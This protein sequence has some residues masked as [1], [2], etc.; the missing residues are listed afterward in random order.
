MDSG[1]GG[2]KLSLLLLL[3]A[4]AFSQSQDLSSSGSCLLANTFKT[5]KKYEYEYTAETENG[6]MG[7]AALTNGPKLSCKVVIEVPQ[8]CRFILS[9]SQCQLSETFANDPDG[10]PVTQPAAGSGAFQA[11]MEKNSLKF[12][13]QDDGEV[14]LFPETDETPTILNVK[15]GIVSALLVPVMEEESSKYME[16]LYGLCKT[17]VTV[18][19][20]GNIANNVTFIR[21][22]SK[23]DRF[24]PM[25]DF[26]SPLAL[27]SGLDFPLSQLIRS[28]Q[29][30]NYQFDD[31]MQHMTTGTCWEKHMF[32][33]FSNQQIYGISAR[34]T[35]TLRLVDSSNSNSRTYDHNEA[36]MKDLYME[37]TADKAPTQIKDTMLAS[38][39]ELNA[40][41]Q[42]DNGEKRA[43]LFHKLVSEI[44]QLRYET[45]SHAVTEMLEVSSLLTW[46]ALAQCGTPECTSAI[47]RIL[48]TF[49]RSSLEIDAVVY[50]MGFL[51]NVNIQDML[52]MAQYKQSKAIMYSLSNTVRRFYQSEL[53]VTPEITA[54]SEFMGSQ[55]GS[56]CSGDKDHIFLTLRV[57]GNM[58]EAMEAASPGLK[59]VLLNCISQPSA[60]LSVQQAAI[61]AFRQMRADE[62]V[63][64]IFLRVVLDGA[65]PVQK[66]LAA[67]LIL[68][69]HPEPA[70]V[71][72][73]IKALP[74]EQ[75][76]QA[77][78]F[79][80]SYLSNILIS[81]DPASED[82]KQ[83]ILDALQG[84]DLP[85]AQDFRKFSQNY[86][87]GIMQGNT[88]FDST[89]YMPK[90]VML[91]T[92]LKA[93]GYHLDLFEVGMEG[94]G[95]EPTIDALFGQNGFFPDIILKTMY[96]A[97]NKMPEKV[98]E[99]LKRW[100]PL[101]KEKTKGQ[102][103]QNIVD[104]IERNFDKLLHELRT[105]QSPEAMAYLRIMGTEL[106]YIKTSEIKGIT[107]SVN[108][109]VDKILRMF[110]KNIL[111]SFLSSTDNEMFAHYIFMD[112]R[113]SL[114]TVAGF[115]LKFSLSAT[116]APGAKGGLRMA[117]RLHEL[118]F[119]PSVGVEFIT[120]MGVHIPEYILSSIDMHT[121]VYHE[122]KL[123][124]RLSVTNNQIKLAFPVPQDTTKLFSISNK[125]LSV[126]STGTLT[127][128]PSAAG[129][130]E[131][132]ECQPLFSGVNYCTTLQYTN[133]GSSSDVPY[134]PLTGESKFAVEVHPTGE[135]TEYTA[136]IT[137]ET[138]KEGK[139]GQH[140]VDT[141]KMTLKA[142]GTQPSEATATV[143]YNRSK[144]VLST[145]IQIPDYDVE[146]GI[147]LSFTDSNARKKGVHSITI[148][149]VNKNV[150]QLS[151]IGRTK[152]EGMKDGQVQLQFIFPALKTEA[153]LTATM[154]NAEEIILDIN[155]SIRVSETSSLQHVI[156]KYDGNI[157]EVELVSDMDSKIQDYFPDTEVYQK[158]INHIL[159]QKVAKTDMKLRHIV[160]KSYEGGQ[161][162]LRK[163]AA[164]VPLLN[165]MEFT[166]PSLP[167]KLFLKSKS[168]F[169]WKFQ[170]RVIV[171][172]A[173]PFG[174][175]SSKR[176]NI[177]EKITVPRLSIPQIGL[178]VPSTEVR[179]PV[180]H[181]P[182]GFELSLPLNDMVEF[183]TVVNSN[184][185]NWEG[186]F[187]VGK[188]TETSYVT[189]FKAMA[190]CPLELLSYSIGGGAAL[191][192]SSTLAK[193][194]TDFSLTH[195]LIDINFNTSSSLVIF[196]IVY[197]QQTSTLKA[198]SPLGLETS[199]YHTYEAKM[200]YSNITERSSTSGSVMVGS[201][202]GNI[203]HVYSG[204][205]DT[206]LE[207]GRAESSLTMSSDVLQAENR[208]VFL[209][210]TGKLAVTSTTRTLNDAVEHMLEFTLS[211]THL[212][213][214]S[215]AVA[216]V[217][218]ITVRNQAELDLSHEAVSITVKSRAYGPRLH[219]FSL[220]SGSLSEN[221]L[222]VQTDNSVN[223]DKSLHTNNA[224]LII[225]LGRL[226]FH[227]N[228]N[229]QNNL[230]TFENI[231][232]GGID[233]TGTSLS[234]S[235][236]GLVQDMKTESTNTLSL[237]STTLLL[238]S[239]TE[240]FV[241][242]SSFYKHNVDVDLK[243]FTGVV[244]MS[245]DL[246]LLD[247]NFLHNGQFKL[248]P[249]K[250]DL[251]GNLKGIIGEENIMHRY[252][253]SFSDLNLSAKSRTNGNVL[254]AH[255]NYISDMEATRLS[256]R[257]NSEVSIKSESLHVTG[258][259]RTLVQ[260][261][262]VSAD[263]ILNSNGNLDWYG[264][265]TSQLYSKLAFKAEPLALACS[266]DLRAST[267]HQLDDT[268]S[269][270]TQLDH[271]IDTLLNPQEQRGMWKVKS[272]LNNHAYDKEIS[273]YNS[274]ERMGIEMSGK[275]T[276]PFLNV[277]DTENQELS[278]SAYLKYDKMGDSHVVELP[279]IISLSGI[280]ERLKMNIVSVLEFFKQNIK[281]EEFR[282]KIQNM[283]KS[284]S[285]YV[286][287]YD[288][289]S[290][291][292]IIK[293]KLI[294]LSREYTVTSENFETF[295]ENLKT[296][297]ER[298]QSYVQVW[299]QS[300]AALLTDIFE[301]GTLGDSV[302]NLLQKLGHEMRAIDAQ[303]K[304][305]SIVVRII[306][307]FEEI[308]I[309][310]QYL[311]SNFAGLQ[312][313][314]AKYE[315][316]ANLLKK[317]GELEQY[318]DMFDIMQLIQESNIGEYVEHLVS[319][320]PIEIMKDVN[321]LKQVIISF[322]EEYDIIE[323]INTANTVLHEMLIKY[324]VDTKIEL[325][326]D[327]VMEFIKLE[328]NKAI[329]TLKH[330]DL[331]TLCDQAIHDLDNAIN[332][333]M[334]TDFREM[335]GQL[336]N[337]IDY[338]A[339][340]M[341]SVDMIRGEVKFPTFGKLYSEIRFNSP[342]Y[343]LIT[344]AELLNSTTSSTTP[345][346]T[347]LL[348][349]KAS[350]AF[351]VLDY[352][353]NATALLAMPTMNHLI[354]DENCMINHIVFSVDHQ[355]SFTV[356]GIS[357]QA[358]GK[359]ITR[360]S[361][362]PY[363]AEFVNNVAL[364]L[365]SEISMTVDNTYSH[366]LNMPDVAVSSRASGTQR[367]YANL[368]SG[369][370]NV[371][372]NNKANGKW[373][374]Q[375]Y[376]DEGSH[377]SDI[378]FT[379][380]ITTAKFNI[381]A[382]TNIQ[383]LKAKQQL[384][385]D[386][387]MLETININGLAETESP[388]IK[389]SMVE[390][391]GNVN[392][393]ELSVKLNVSHS[394]ELLGTVTG[395]I[396][397]SIFFYAHPEELAFDF[398]NK[399]N[400]KISLPVGLTAK[401]DLQNDYSVILKN[402]LQQ[403][404]WVSLARFNQYK[405]SHNFTMNNNNKDAGIYAKI[406]GDAN[407]DFLDVSI[408][409]PAVDMLWYRTPSF[410]KVSLWKHTG[411][412]NILTTPQQSLNMDYRLLY[413]KTQDSVNAFGNLTSDLSFKS[414]IITLNVNTAL[415]KQN[416]IVAR[417]VVSSTSVFDALKG[418]FLGNINLTTKKMVKLAIILSAE[419]KNFEATHSSAVSRTKKGVDVSM[420]TISKV[421]CPMIHLEFNQELTGNS[422]TTSKAISR[423]KLKYSFDLPI[424][425]AIGQ[426][427][428]GHHFNLEGTL[429]D[430]SLETITKGKTV[431][432]INSNIKFINVINHD[433]NTFMNADGLRSSMKT[434]VIFQ[435][436]HKDRKTWNM[437][438]KQDVA[439]DA[440]LN[441]VYAVLTYTNDNEANLLFLNTKGK[442]IATATLNLSPVTSLTGKVHID[443]SQPT[444]FGE[445]HLFQDIV[446]EVT[447]WKQNFSWEGSEKLSSL[448]HAHKL[449]LSNNMAEQK[450]EVSSSW[451]GHVAFLKSIN[452]PIYQKNLW[453]VLKFDQVT[454]AEKLQ[455]LK[456]SSDVVH[457]QSQ[458]GFG[459]NEISATATLSCPVYTMTWT[460][461][462][463]NQ[464]PKFI[465]SLKSS[466]T[467]TLVFLEFDLD[468]TAT[469][470]FEDNTVGLSGRGTFRHHD[471]NIDWKHVCTHPLSTS[472]HTLTVDVTSPTFTNLKIQY[473]SQD[474]S[475]NADIFSS[476]CGLL[477]FRLEKKTPSQIYGLL[478]S[479]YLNAPETDTDILSIRVS[480]KNPERLSLQTSWNMRPVD[481]MT[482][483]LVD[484]VP[485]ITASFA[486]LVNKYHK[487]LFG[488][489]IKSTAQELKRTV[490]GSIEEAYRRVT[491]EMPQSSNM[492]SLSVI[493]RNVVRQCNKNM[494]AVF[495]SA[496]LALSETYI[497]LPG[498]H[499][500]LTVPQ[501]WEGTVE[502]SFHVLKIYAHYLGAVTS[503]FSDIMVVMPFTENILTWKE[504]LEHTEASMKNLDLTTFRDLF[505]FIHQLVEHIFGNLIYEYL[506]PFWAS[507]NKIYS[508]ALFSVKTKMG[509]FQA[510]INME[511]LNKVLQDMIGAIALH[512]RAFG[513]EVIHA[514]QQLASED[515]QT[516]IQISNNH[517]EI[518]IPL[519]LIH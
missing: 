337:Y 494:Q 238:Q 97:E 419:S 368:E 270:K 480:L 388:F 75:D 426:G 228:T 490:Y 188:D 273:V 10:V 32:L 83:M 462:L 222:E 453:E 266:H 243:P 141:L 77:K 69:K 464:A 150:P 354:I 470:N 412:M 392:M 449:L 232:K 57:L 309:R 253:V 366:K 445:G 54:V 482:S 242:K 128:S 158:F 425:N 442:H 318:V 376:S 343:N 507:F 468:A 195:N 344:N 308:I 352:T 265:H 137:Y 182:Q 279:F 456:F 108:M 189:K 450:M 146:A 260:P 338:I 327:K 129:R 184:V 509:D 457:T 49:D 261:F 23:C 208:I 74:K 17:E 179:I 324:E 135:I 362:E 11:A 229:L 239:K 196:H 389:N 383:D 81:Q 459:L 244:I 105:Q 70:D 440:S 328:I 300:F 311:D 36:N 473:A 489:E 249:Y 398:L 12:M 348:N 14:K 79:I 236:K 342:Y 130:I 251:F 428:I 168:K 351:E 259:V 65:S 212:S 481:D 272:K 400:T 96:W 307:A 356:N 52:I 206:S 424:I 165:M 53:K 455:F 88:I 293:E 132:T 505:Y 133:T 303:Y 374:V 474:S 192:Y 255:I 472:H 7:P 177:P 385:V 310:S 84:N 162:W 506:D 403:A 117:P 118:S 471:L 498:L 305:S 373:A 120:Q 315:I 372:I 43:G 100:M 511:Q 437:D 434:N 364:A 38:M 461:G 258:T 435:V 223:F 85:I 202:H 410:E 221:G 334:E 451:D 169:S 381:E 411:L 396:S 405:Y 22:L 170:D 431:G 107:Q 495:N 134:F 439:L 218:S 37:A 9:T 322:M 90:E 370:F 409:I 40:L 237:T 469:A 296:S 68:M 416:D 516:Y 276:S 486:N 209:Y 390:L 143:K 219:A 82:I 19:S 256:T 465:T 347:A 500:T 499:E 48:R 345:Q 463:E 24:N 395:T 427:D 76:P 26:T 441:R 391:H 95:F 124:T 6:V 438:M 154:T 2:T 200:D 384:N 31:K 448:S 27:M 467:S 430:I 41:S 203:N 33:P 172:V 333:Q 319:Q 156:F 230:L 183:S 213:L 18:S 131:S 519:Q 161:I 339:N 217:L 211:D 446:L 51:P 115:P 320:I 514:L 393:E 513:S 60:A 497:Q 241:G 402:E 35:Q 360:T 234:V 429:R 235:S 421:I 341:K 191:S 414:A 171:G 159:D 102:V 126:T 371:K 361:T 460:A 29:T 288:M 458:G 112:N 5:F 80:A 147:R 420:S 418:K 280:F 289:D 329:N 214:T 475:I 78:S 231:I 28:T 178:E 197:L 30:C 355:G 479:R 314:D 157:A 262:I 186:S 512:L 350:S 240:N 47:L 436:S 321:N 42:T 444:S 227:V 332:N 194:T 496:D 291:I 292:V 301:N 476:T 423:M 336:N 297:T 176:L 140:K 92:T 263:I 492:T 149:I 277:A 56:D 387:V 61:Q 484:K 487:S 190:D 518:N 109:F 397:N 326:L 248:E 20:R 58:G 152:V 286:Q 433:V 252:E 317:L 16:T 73:V 139:E 247:V 205:M 491:N 281:N 59:K 508:K 151:L 216:K 483:G 21:D 215:N 99:V 174:G 101:Q 106:G 145:D 160:S 408:N 3:S 13:V 517:L 15:R 422:K 50:S 91:E 485:V 155:S 379:T 294:A 122:S 452:L 89:G 401:I 45:L 136:A 363:T 34:V 335:T 4:T 358:S 125:L 39:R 290:K 503:H 181:I 210:N 417:I 447:P 299:V 275:V 323:T 325:F 111:K 167:E 432:I 365:G 302:N 478:Y 386:S 198:S 173:L 164:N 488:M 113:F 8:T 104:Q 312:D 67:Y 375:E 148:D 377:Q 304:I 415:Y 413:R 93:F 271:K 346:F 175:M 226:A 204:E 443:M 504:Y 62:E 407:L 64:R 380:D 515:T 264:K 406:N 357:A 207:R 142:E 269:I 250:M 369:T 404:S 501:L 298:I 454:S 394:T 193:A 246:K 382:S 359:T 254:G 199:V 63:R 306:N 55:L 185:Y 138:V 46:Q 316:R 257:F 367:V 502:S 180:F 233:S 353:L 153:A 477:G 187:S 72:T 44:R 282:T 349:S 87:M 25:K 378:T 283:F 493:F 1:M 340:G 144:N 225:S 224:S 123:N 114:P 94:K 110:P 71:A 268:P 220:I 116:F 201:F 284:V 245:N 274:H 98:N 103:P 295:L 330:I 121:T 127:I 66:R 163:V 287:E 331:L 86:K 313:L 267:T 466:C 510:E 399:Q 278:I 285:Y 166:L 119:R